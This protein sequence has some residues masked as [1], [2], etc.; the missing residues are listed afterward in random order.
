M[1]STSVERRHPG[2]LIPKDQHNPQ[3]VWLMQQSVGSAMIRHIV[4]EVENV[5]VIDESAPSIK[6][7]LSSLPSPP[8]TPTKGSFSDA[9][10]TP[11]AE[12]QQPSTPPIPT[13]EEFI[14]L[15][16]QRSNVQA[17]TLLT[18]L[19]YLNK[20]KNKLPK[21]AKG[22]QWCLLSCALHPVPDPPLIYDLA[23]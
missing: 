4:S 11:G 15:L 21:M 8:V 17:S 18:T 9:S 23:L 22:G 20:L 19:I 2:S 7:A 5:I 3:L 1:V 13:L 14:L 10:S 12:S 6:A 16:C